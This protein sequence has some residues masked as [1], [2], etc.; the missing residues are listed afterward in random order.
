MRSIVWR[1]SGSCT[2]ATNLFD[3]YGISSINSHLVQHASAPNG[4]EQCAR[5]PLQL[6]Y[7]EQ[8]FQCYSK[9]PE[10]LQNQSNMP[11]IEV[12]DETEVHE[13]HCNS[14]ILSSCQLAACPTIP[15]PNHCG[16]RLGKI[17]EITRTSP[18]TFTFTSAIPD[19]TLVSCLIT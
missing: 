11:V 16:F 14:C 19:C 8:L 12:R 15:C 1:D 2:V 6:Q 18:S 10:T 4:G 3:L 17:C 13:S 7:L 5:V 9:L